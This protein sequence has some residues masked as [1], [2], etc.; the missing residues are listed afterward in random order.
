MILNR[1]FLF[2]GTPVAYSTDLGD[3]MYPLIAAFLAAALFTAVGLFLVIKAC[4][5]FKYYDLPDQRK[6]HHAPIPRLG[7]VV[8]MP[9]AIVG[10]CAALYAFDGDRQIV[11][12]IST[13]AMVMGAFM[14]YLIGIFDDRVGMKASHKFI[15]QG[16]SALFLPLCGLLITNING[17]FGMHEI[18]LWVGYPLTVLL[19]MTI[20][21]AIN[22]IDGIDGLASGLCILILSAYAYVFAINGYMLI[23]AINVSIVGALVVFFGFN[24]FGRVGRMKIFMGDS[25]SLFLGYVCAYMSIKSLLRPIAPVDC[26]EEQMLIAVTLLLIPVMDVVRVALQRW[27]TGRWIFDPDRNHIHH[28]FMA[29]GLSMHKALLAIIVMFALICAINYAMW[30]A[31]F[32]LAIILFVDLIIYAFVVTTLLRM[33]RKEE[34]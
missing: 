19:I 24:F 21:N 22:L 2:Y 27:A 25:G 6:V 23:A 17:I 28:L 31:H 20:V 7:G 32:V 33:G 18:P 13:L 1:I 34:D 11:I 9:A 29:A 8:F 10:L 30:Q 3:A 16:I 14:I 4:H 26:G 5:Y 12:S 15:I